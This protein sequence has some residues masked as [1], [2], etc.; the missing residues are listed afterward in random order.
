MRGPLW[1]GR[2]AGYLPTLLQ[3]RRIALGLTLREVAALLGVTS[4]PV[5]V[6]ERQEWGQAAL[7]VRLENLLGDLEARIGHDGRTAGA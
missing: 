4:G 3:A 7:R 5:S 2:Y 6:A 1:A